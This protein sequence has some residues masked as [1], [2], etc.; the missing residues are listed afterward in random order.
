M[1]KKCLPSYGLF[2]EDLPL[3]TVKESLRHCKSLK[4]DD[5]FRVFGDFYICHT[6]LRILKTCKIHPGLS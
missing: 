3:K 2:D 1:V 5:S 4:L 6:C